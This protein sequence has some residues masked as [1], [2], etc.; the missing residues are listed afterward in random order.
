MPERQPGFTLFRILPGKN[1]PTFCHRSIRGVVFFRTSAIA[2][3]TPT[4]CKIPKF[5]L[6]FIHYTNRFENIVLFWFEWHMYIPISVA[7]AQ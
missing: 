6:L 2:T 5:S 3:I 4:K 1:L 7:G